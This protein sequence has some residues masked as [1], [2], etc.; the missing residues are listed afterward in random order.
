[1]GAQTNHSLVATRGFV[2]GARGDEMAL[3]EGLFAA[4]LALSSSQPLRA[5]LADASQDVALRQKLAGRAFASLSTEVKSLVSQ[6][7][8]LRWSRPGDLQMAFEEMGIRLAA[9]SAGANADVVGEL[10]AISTLVHGNAD[11]ELGLGSKR[12]A[13]S[14]RSALMKKL[15]G[16]KV[17]AQATA[18]AAHLVADPRGRRIGAM[19]NHAAEVVAD[20]HGKGLA[21]VQ[22]SQ[23]LSDA[24]R[25]HIDTL[26][27]HQFGRAHY[28]AEQVLP[29]VIGGARIRVGDMIIDGS[30]ASRL[31]DL[32]TQ[33]AG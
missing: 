1:M 33:L 20:E 9:Q 2:A 26:L 6:T 30:I 8:E 28:L 32:R 15:V 14:A 27:V 18:I 5:Q 31:Q 4:A 22:V 11:V 13:S 19:L 23:P 16:S 3:A 7:V 12:A 24:Q 17:S 10:L 21:V 25:S 29:A